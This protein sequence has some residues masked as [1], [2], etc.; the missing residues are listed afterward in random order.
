MKKLSG[1]WLGFTFAATLACAPHLQL[2]V[3]NQGQSTHELLPAESAACVRITGAPFGISE[4][5]LPAI[6]AKSFSIR[7]FGAV[8]DGH[9][10]NTE[11][12][13]KAISACAAAGGGKVIVPPGIWLTGPIRLE[14]KINLHLE[15]GALVLFST[16]HS[17]YPIITAPARGL[18]VAPPLYG[19]GLEDVAITGMGILDGAGESWR[20]V[21]KFK[22]TSSQWKELLQSGG[23]VDEKVNMWWPSLA[24]MNGADYLEKLQAVKKKKEI[25]PEDFLPARDF[26]RPYM[27]SLIDCRRVLIEGVTIKN[28]PKF[29]LCPAWCEEMVIR[30]IKVNNEWWAQNG[31]GIDISACR[32]VLVERCTVTA[33][34][35]GICMK[36]SSRSGHSAPALENIIIRD[37]IVY[38]GHGGFVVGS[39][40]DGGI[41]SILVENCTFIGTDV[42][43]RFK[44]SR[45]RGGVVEDIQIRKIFMRDIVNEAILFD[46]FYEAERL[47]VIAHPVTGE[48]P[49]FRG[50]SMD[51]IYCVGAGQAIAMA[52]LPEMPIQEISIRN[53]AFTTDKGIGME[54]VQGIIFKNIDLNPA[55]GPVFAFKQSSGIVLDK[56]NYP[57]GAE[58]MLQLTGMESGSVTVKSSDLSHARTQ[59]QW[60]TPAVDGAVI[61]K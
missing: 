25:T 20:P 55:Q 36:S 9:F 60:T 52:G 24:A 26:L 10:L 59:V 13:Q 5:R 19:F 39:N 49:V 46:S 23:V 61:I 30:D 7:E 45:G 12:I 3:K 2:Q 28:S 34:D 22:T 38:H 27:V 40:T 17:L 31:D 51:S 56:I 44:S 21:K 32:N 54:L 57:D 48:T 16:D 11:A 1:L 53:G 37:C 6:P 8:G 43:L 47:D 14:S 58:V 41:R 15:A 33:G 4:I 42:G 35:D 18:G 50:I 29:A